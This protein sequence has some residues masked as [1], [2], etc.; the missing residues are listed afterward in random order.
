MTNYSTIPQAGRRARPGLTHRARSAWGRLV[1]PEATRFENAG[2]ITG[3]LLGAAWSVRSARRAGLSTPATVLS[4][5]FALDLVGGAWTN[6]TP[7]CK[8]WYHRPGTKPTSHLA[9]AAAHVHPHLL[10]R[11]HPLGWRYGVAHHAYLLAATA[12]VSITPRRVAPPLATV[13]ALGGMA[14]DARLGPP[15][16]R[17]WVMP[18]YYVKLLPGHAVGPTGDQGA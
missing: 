11:S 14:L 4:T 15:S 6:M 3:A 12:V 8:R 10:A 17:A 2:T 18:A 1:G 9:F 13:L 7:S 5:V 16:G